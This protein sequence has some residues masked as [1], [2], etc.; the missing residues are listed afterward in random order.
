L[1]LSTPLKTK[2]V[3]VR[4]PMRLATNVPKYELGHGKFC[5]AGPIARS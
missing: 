3:A 5:R 2:S 4:W 1:H